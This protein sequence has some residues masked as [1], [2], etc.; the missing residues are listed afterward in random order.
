MPTPRPRSS[1]ARGPVARTPGARPCGYRVTDEVRVELQMAAAFTDRSSL[2]AVIDLAVAE[3]LE[4][5]RRQDG[6]VDAVTKANRARR[7]SR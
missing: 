2:Q 3:F 7:R 5:M 4:R 6:F 1:G